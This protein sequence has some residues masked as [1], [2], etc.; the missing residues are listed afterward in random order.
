MEGS[1][2]E[3][4]EGGED[5]EEVAEEGGVSDDIVIDEAEW[6]AKEGAKAEGEW[7][8]KTEIC[9][10]EQRFKRPGP[11]T[12][13]VIHKKWGV[14]CKN[15]NLTH[16]WKGGLV[17]CPYIRKD[18]NI[19]D[20]CRYW[21]AGRGCKKGTNCRWVHDMSIEQRCLWVH[22]ARVDRKPQ[23]RSWEK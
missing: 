18:A 21:Q 9:F 20:L 7:W 1:R 10:D 11:Y 5:S 4:K 6:C 13:G 14:I 8:Q 22:G 2:Q 17:G 16:S 15:G 19:G 23:R 3:G 12:T